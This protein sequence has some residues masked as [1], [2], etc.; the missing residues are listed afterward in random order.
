MAVNSGQCMNNLLCAQ[1]GPRLFIWLITQQ[2]LAHHTFAFSIANLRYA[3]YVHFN[4]NSFSTLSL[5]SKLVLFMRD[6]IPALKKLPKIS[7]E[8][9]L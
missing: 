9:P 4:F 3:A 8:V 2:T 5:A 1:D 7:P 6:F